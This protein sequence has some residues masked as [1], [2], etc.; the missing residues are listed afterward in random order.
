M[1]R[2]EKKTFSQL[3]CQVSKP[4]RTTFSLSTIPDLSKSKYYFRITEKR[5][6]CL[7]ISSH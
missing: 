7:H 6:K 3:L 2:N 5:R 1:N 4:N